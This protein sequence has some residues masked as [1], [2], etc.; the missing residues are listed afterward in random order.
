MEDDNFGNNDRSI[1]EKIQ[2][3]GS[4]TYGVV[5]KAVNKKT[6]EGM[7]HDRVNTIDYQILT[8][9]VD[10]NIPFWNAFRAEM[11]V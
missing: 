9:L 4:G 6:N 1:F 2:Q 8:K 5:F 3:I 11:S 10:A 7:Y